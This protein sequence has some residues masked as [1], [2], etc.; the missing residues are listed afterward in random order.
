[1]KNTHKQAINAYNILTS[2]GKRVTGKTAYDLF[3]LKLNLKS[4]YDFQSEEELK[5][6]EKYHAK[7]K[8][9]GSVVIDDPEERKAFIEEREKLENLECDIDHITLAIDDIPDITMN[10]IEAL[11]SFVD[12][13]S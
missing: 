7:V 1:M 12:F 3:Q 8:D 5:L 9:N 13:I 6:V 4:I 11:Y 10:E 2:L